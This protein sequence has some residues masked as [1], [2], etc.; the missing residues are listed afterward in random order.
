VKNR[1][2]F[3]KRS[4][5]RFR[6][7]STPAP[8]P[9]LEERDEA[10]FTGAEDSLVDGAFAVEDDGPAYELDERTVR[11]RAPE[12]IQRRKRASK[13]V[14]ACTLFCGLLLG[15][16]LVKSSRA[17]RAEGAQAT[18]HSI[19]ATVRLSE[20]E[21]AVVPPPSVEQAALP[22]APEPVAEPVRD[23][24]AAKA[25]KLEAQALLDRGKLALAIEAG[26]EA[27]AL[28]SDDAEA[29]LTLGAAQQA[30]GDSKN[31]RDS[32]SRCTKESKRGPKH[33]CFA[34]LR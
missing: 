9:N 31:A 30:K 16:G 13:Y 19:P 18:T 24:K 22:A 11:L 33:E 4:V 12:V 34:M 20:P 25:K 26:Q 23:P 27:V 3:R 32:F 15:L 1:T 29:W 28:D 14:A 6:R 5:D 10:F 7:A 2:A 17:A 8:A 21:A